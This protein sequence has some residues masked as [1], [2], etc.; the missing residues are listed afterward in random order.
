MCDLHS[1][2]KNQTLKVSKVICQANF[3]AVERVFWAKVDL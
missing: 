3:N 1:W 2:Q